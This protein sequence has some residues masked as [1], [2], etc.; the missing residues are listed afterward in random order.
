MLT[1]LQFLLLPF[2]LLAKARASKP[3]PDGTWFIG[4]T[5]STSYDL[6]SDHRDC[7]CCKH[8]T[9]SIVQTVSR[10]QAERQA[11]YRRC[12]CTPGSISRTALFAEGTW[13]AYGEASWSGADWYRKQ[14]VVLMCHVHDTVDVQGTIDHNSKLKL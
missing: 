7:T 8:T 4:A 13:I 3:K 6:V 14:P 9:H 5:T 11:A 12:T 10:E 2:T 1:R